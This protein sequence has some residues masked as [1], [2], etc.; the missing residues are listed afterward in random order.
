MSKNPGKDG[1]GRRREDAFGLGCPMN[2]SNTIGKERIGEW[3]ANTARPPVSGRVENGEGRFDERNEAWQS[4]CPECGGRVRSEVVE[5]VCDECGL[6][7]LVEDVDLKPTLQAHAPTTPGRIGEWAVEP[8]DLLRVDKGLV[9]TFF[10]GSD[11]KGNSLSPAQRSRMWRLKARHKR[12]TMADKRDQRLNEGFHDIR[13]LGAN[14]GLPDH[15]LGDAARYLKAASDAWLPG[16]RMAWE[17]LAGGAVLLACRETSFERTPAEVAEYTKTDEER[18]CA[19]ARKI[20]TEAGLE[21]PVVRERA[22]DLVVEGLEQVGVELTLSQG[23]ARSFRGR[24]CRPSRSVRPRAPHA[25]DR[26][27]P[28]FR[29]P[30]PSH[31]WLLPR[32][33]S[34]GSRRL[35]STHGVN[36]H[37]SFQSAFWDLTFSEGRRHLTPSGVRDT[38]EI[39]P[40]YLF[41]SHARGAFVYV[42]CSPRVTAVAARRHMKRFRSG[43]QGVGTHTDDANSPLIASRPIRSEVTTMLAAGGSRCVSACA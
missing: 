11:G 42:Y 24:V 6:V 8:V 18:V 3:T 10:L 21:A 1:V 19:A 35:G 14:L 9:T 38:Q 28:R 22:V 29:R 37:D 31:P 15:V 34:E 5:W 32:R 20:R 23:L 43:A 27:R 16:G 12:F 7:V 4:R 26:S 33:L 39:E 2:S 17:S 30:A 40:A 41:H 13:L 25:R 36:F